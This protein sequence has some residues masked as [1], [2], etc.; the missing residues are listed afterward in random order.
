MN[1]ILNKH[2]HRH[3]LPITVKYA[4]VFAHENFRFIHSLYHFSAVPL[5]LLIYVKSILHIYHISS[6][7]LSIK[8]KPFLSRP[9]NT[10]L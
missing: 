9:N 7:S 5:I 6:L 2:F 3:T 10:A 1:T 4:A 8:T